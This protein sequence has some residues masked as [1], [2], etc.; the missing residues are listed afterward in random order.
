MRRRP[1][2][3]L[4]GHDREQHAVGRG[5]VEVVDAVGVG[6]VIEH[7]DATFAE[8]AEAPMDVHVVDDRVGRAVQR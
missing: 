4:G 1:G 6:E 2:P 5:V 8:P 3:Q 7:G